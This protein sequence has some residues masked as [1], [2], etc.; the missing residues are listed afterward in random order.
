MTGRFGLAPGSREEKMLLRAEGLYDFSRYLRR[1]SATR[2]E[3]RLDMD[4]FDY[5]P[6]YYGFRRYGNL[7]M[8]EPLEYTESFKVEAL[9]IAIDTSGSC[10]RPVVERFLAEIERMLMRHDSFFSKMEI[11][12][13]QCDAVVQSHAVIRSVEA[14][15][16]Y[17][18][19]LV[20]RGRGGT[21]FTPVFDLV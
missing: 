7:P 14:W 21:N 15:K 16:R 20:V 5:I 12:I 4:S 18:K 6:Y 11:H 9:V 2:E 17:A 19:D 10:T 8:I 1:F 13:V 3:L